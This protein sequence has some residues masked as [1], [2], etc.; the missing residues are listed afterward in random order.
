[1]QSE[2]SKNKHIE[3][4]TKNGKSNRISIPEYIL[5]IV[6]FP[7]LSKERIV[8]PPDDRQYYEY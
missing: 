2:R 1:M 7:F 3:T 6:Y 4:F 8:C 5:A